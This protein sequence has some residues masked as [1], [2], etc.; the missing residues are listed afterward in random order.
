MTIGITLPL[1]FDPITREILEDGQPL[2]KMTSPLYKRGMSLDIL[3]AQITATEQK[4]FILVN[5]VNTSH[6]LIDALTYCKDIF[7]DLHR[8]SIDP[9]CILEPIDFFRLGEGAGIAIKALDK[10]G[11]KC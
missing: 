5:T 2:A 6:E 1:I 7:L 3:K 8:K 10:A 11:V 4:G 9:E